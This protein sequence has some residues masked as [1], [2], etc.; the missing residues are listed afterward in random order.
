MKKVYKFRW[1]SLSSGSYLL[2]EFGKKYY[3]RIAEGKFQLDGI[4]GILDGSLILQGETMSEIVETLNG[5][6]CIDIRKF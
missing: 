4:A 5:L 1:V 6:D 3:F 2:D